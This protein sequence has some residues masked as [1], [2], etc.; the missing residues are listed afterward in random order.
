M[1]SDSW[2]SKNVRPLCLLVLTCSIVAGLYAS[3]VGKDKFEALVD[4]ANFVYGY[5]FI[6]RSAE[7]TVP[8]F[9]RAKAVK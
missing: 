5:Y 3:D 2:L 4:M 7:W 9:G 1:K 8:A 6:R